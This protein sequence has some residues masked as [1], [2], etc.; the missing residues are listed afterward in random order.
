M[1]S[2]LET[3]EKPPTTQDGEQVGSTA[4]FSLDS[5]ICGDNCEVMRQWP[6]KCIDLVV[7]SPP[8][9]DLRTYGGHE[10]DFY[11]VSWNLSRLLKPGGVIVWNVADATKNGSETG[12]SMR[13]ALQFQR[14]GLNLHDTMI[15]QK[16]SYMPLTHNRY[17]QA[18][19][20][21]FVL[22]KGRP[23]YWNPIK[24]PCTTAGTKRNRGGSKQREVT[25][26]E[27]RREERTEVKSTKQAPNVFIYDVGK[28][29]K[30]KH[31]APFPH[32]MARDVIKSWSDEGCIVLDPFAGSGTTLKAAKELNRRYVGIEVNPEYVKICE[33]RTMQES[34]PLYCENVKASR[35]RAGDSPN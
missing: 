34:L 9:D 6:D 26:A 21:L 30:T 8:Y 20:Y 16:N 18:W 35:C 32:D 31:N 1:G 14:L 27:R 19:E 7:T 23:K 22:S 33:E 17:E 10:W 13:Q 11:G 15:Y 28:N 4:L 2:G 12:T 3:I 29:D 25:Y 5:V 24:V